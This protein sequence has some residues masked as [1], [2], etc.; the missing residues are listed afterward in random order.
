MTKLLAKAEAYT[1]S[2]SDIAITAMSC[3]MPGAS[4]PEAFWD[5]LR[6]GVESISSFDDERLLAA[7]VAPEL[8]KHPD[9]VKAGAILSNVED[10]DAFFFDISGREAEL[11]DPQHRIFLECAWEALERSGYNPRS[12][13]DNAIGMYAGV[14]MNGYLLNNLVPY[15]RQ[16]ASASS[17]VTGY[18]AFMA[19][20]KD[21]APTRASYKLNLKG[22]S[23]N[24][25]TACSSSL[26]AVHM[27]C[28]SLLNGEC[29]M[30]LAGAVAIGLPQI[31]GYLYQEGMIMSPDG[32][33][34]AFDAQ[35]QGTVGGRGAGV[36]VLKRLEDALADGDVIE[37][38]IK[39]S[40]INNDGAMK[41]GYA[42]PS[43]NGQAAVIAEAM[44]I[45]EVDPRSISYVE[46]HGT[47]T[48]LG[49]PIEVAA[50]TKAFR[51]QTGDKEFCAIGS[52][53]TNLGH[54][55][56]AAGMAGLIKTVLALKHQEIPASL[57]F[58]N[59][60]PQIDFAN[61]PF[62][63]NTELSPWKIDAHP[64]RA[65][66]SSFGMGGTNAHVVLEEAPPPSVRSSKA[67]TPPVVGH[68]REAHLLLLS[69]KTATA[70]ETA[71]QN[72]ADYL[73][74]H[75]QQDLA[76]VAY[77]L[78][79]GRRR[80]PHRR[81]VVC[82][83]VEEGITALREV[84]PGQVFTRHKEAETEP[85]T[86]L[87]SEKTGC[88][89]RQ[90]PTV[91]KGLYEREPVF[92]TQVDRCAELLLPHLGLDVRSLLYPQSPQQIDEATEKLT[93][94]S[95]NQPARF[96]IKYALSQL[97]MS[98]GV[99]P[100]SLVGDD[101]GE[102]VAA[103]LA[104]VFSLSDAL[105]LVTYRSQL[106]QKGSTD[107]IQTNLES[108]RF[109]VFLQDVNL[110]A[111][112]IP[113]FSNVTGTWVT[114]EQATRSAY[115]VEQMLQP[116]CFEDALMQLFVAPA[117][118][119]L[120]I[121][122]GPQATSGK[123][124]DTVCF[125]RSLG[126]LWLAGCKIDWPKVYQHE[127]R[128]RVPLPTYPFERQRYWLEPSP[129]PDPE[130]ETTV[131]KKPVAQPKAK[132]AEMADWFYT[133]TWKRVVAS[134]YPA[135][136]LT[137]SLTWLIFVDDPVDG[138]GLG[139]A[140]IEQLKR[141]GQCAIAI[142][143]SDRFEALTSEQYHL[144]PQDAGDYEQLFTALH[145]QDQLPDKIVHLWSLTTEQ[146]LEQT[147]EKATPASLTARLERVDNMQTLGFF[148][149]LH[150][151]KALGQQTFSSTVSLSVVSNHMQSVTGDEQLVPEKATLLGPCQVIS[152]ENPD[153]HCQSIDVVWP[154][155]APEQATLTIRQLWADLMRD[156]TNSTDKIVAYRGQHR[157]IRTY[158][159]IQLPAQN[160]SFS[161]RLRPQG[162]YLIT[163]GLG[164]L[165][166][167]LAEHLAKTVEAK[168]VLTGQ[169]VF[170]VKEAW[171]Q[172]LST[173][174][175]DDRISDKIRKLQTIE[176]LGSEVL[177]LGVDV[178]DVEAMTALVNQVKT[179]WGE[180]HGVIHAAGLPGGG[181]IQR[182][183]VP[184]AMKVLSPKLQ[185]TLILAS[186]VPSES[187]D[188]MVL[189]SSINAVLGGFGQVDYC[190]ANAFL[191]TFAHHHANRH[192]SLGFT[193]G[194]PELPRALVTSINWDAWQA[195][196]MAVDT[197]VPDALKVA[198][199]ESLKLGMPTAS[200]IEAF[201][202]ILSSVLPQV[203]VSTHDLAARL[204]AEKSVATQ[205]SLPL[206]AQPS[207]PMPDHA[208]EISPDVSADISA[209]V[210]TDVS[211]ETNENPLP[212]RPALATVY[213]G[214]S[215]QTEREIAALWQNI[216]RVDKIGIHDNFF[217]LGGDSLTGLQV[218][219]QLNQAF[220]V[221]LPATTLYKAPTVKTLSQLLQPSSLPSAIKSVIKSVIKPTIESPPAPTANPVPQPIA[222]HPQP[223]KKSQ[224]TISQPA[225]K[226]ASQP[227]SKPAAQKSPTA[228]DR[229]ARGAKRR[230]R[231]LRQAQ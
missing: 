176:A 202:R 146:T 45:A 27:A 35:A 18:Q 124:S 68:Q 25:N 104:G 194:Q 82:S 138:Q 89:Y 88:F 33:C 180:I 76:D 113:Y 110:S 20:D 39:G 128:Y 91:E 208:S 168:F 217:D 60:N 44:A 198:R 201:E 161:S 61:S 221:K 174:A 38:V 94:V 147:L 120:E 40:A 37:A 178:T 24:V 223:V 220:S 62:Y 169:S 31:S 28:Q 175:E 141:E 29:D 215:N 152:Q 2:D 193:D 131:L 231:Q 182:K 228:Q 10:F 49:D 23:V 7:G 105:V 150:L 99:K 145:A 56:T 191:D 83:S 133:P 139:A 127:R 151:S 216:I 50:L 143:P 148:S 114:T 159:P 210:S 53:K 149:L 181:V 119:L 108:S 26:V 51:K 157:W 224:S 135:R 190:A 6:A 121:G 1:V 71:T 34:R 107:L 103:C 140:L 229:R 58:E 117:P 96:T 98:W 163:G 213:V 206:S 173:H 97:W 130:P 200:G 79:V 125:L 144:N 211:A 158:E 14:G 167:A 142:Y 155:A 122:F 42:A 9:Y 123:Q 78:Q 21:F 230:A 170:P 77:T 164:G 81:T 47:A 93:Q 84:K 109:G 85:V 226:S 132:L 166:L 136:P 30:A 189:F 19:N 64:R 196:G 199:A 209:D 90:F 225:A 177:A 185:G 179:Q 92:R 74:Q 218:M 16:T 212:P 227:V 111:P 75:P 126:E 63:V 3:R 17:K 52:V 48:P 86:F 106:M 55:D 184:E 115:W 219:A 67:E 207:E 203:V 183:S 73:S 54:L 186:L 102:Y 41:V 165:G 162:V 101:L 192:A 156:P 137:E 222:A 5:N 116:V 11:M 13:H 172:W 87:F 188:F 36:V 65:G 134:A 129:T 66:V 112:K 187:L 204:T 59:P 80:F 15:F 214:P 12:T 8:L 195:V 69:A 95:F 154:S 43:V 4:T 100:Q 57:H 32:H 118:K 70:L 205:S 46:A 153:I 160:K 171:L 197:A 22:P 72:L